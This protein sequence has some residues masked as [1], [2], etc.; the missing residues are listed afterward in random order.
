MQSK[1]EQPA[2]VETVLYQVADKERKV[3]A[4]L[5]QDAK[6]AQLRYLASVSFIVA[7]EQIREGHYDETTGT[8]Y[9]NEK[10]KEG[11]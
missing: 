10:I 2:R 5:Q 4:K 6:D 11:V 3:L 9:S 8:F 7:R 1:G